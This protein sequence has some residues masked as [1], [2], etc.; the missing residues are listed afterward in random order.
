MHVPPVL[1][2]GLS[3]RLGVR[4]TSPLLSSLGAL[5]LVGFTVSPFGRFNAPVLPKLNAF[6]AVDSPQPCGGGLSVP[7][8]APVGSLLVLHV[9]VGTQDL[10]VLL[11]VDRVFHL[12]KPNREK[13]RKRAAL[14]GRRHA[15]P[16]D[17]SYRHDLKYIQGFLLPPAFGPLVT[18]GA[19][20]FWSPFAQYHPYQA[21]EGQPVM[22]GATLYGR[23][24][25]GREWQALLQPSPLSIGPLYG[26]VPPPAPDEP[27]EPLSRRDPR[28]A[29]RATLLQLL[30]S[31]QVRQFPGFPP[32]L[33]GELLT[34][35]LADDQHFAAIL[36]G[37]LLATHTGRTDNRDV[38]HVEP[39]PPSGASRADPMDSLLLALALKPGTVLL[40]AV[41]HPQNASIRA[42]RRAP[43]ALESRLAESEGDV[44]RAM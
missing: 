9:R 14:Q 35:Y 8:T 41:C 6:H 7:L 22:L 33:A 44:R 24:L 21:A 40:R 37:L 11:L 25:P 39:P 23:T 2:D 30:H 28:A 34:A 43:S 5:G 15:E 10:D 26:V 36:L 38:R 32:L 3:E 27:V 20:T 29:L 1:T 19:H 13:A 17:T 18:S 16:E 42:G 31:L 4:S 12:P